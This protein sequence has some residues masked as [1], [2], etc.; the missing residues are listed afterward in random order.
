MLSKCITIDSI[1]Q[2]QRDIIKE[3][4]VLK[5]D[6]E[7]VLDYMIDI[8][9][10][11]PKLAIQD[12]IPKNLIRGCLSKVWLVPKERGGRLFFTGE[13]NTSITTGL[14]SLLI[15]IFSG[16]K[17]KAITQAPLFFM[18]SIGLH[19]IIGIQRRNGFMLIKDKIN[20]YAKVQEKILF[21]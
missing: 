7:L 2:I 6:N 17:A 14:L 19:K 15:R 9:E 13:S 5:D 16:Q 11:M 3:F 10:Q 21:E 8:G 4:E 1:A 18:E 20:K 12:K